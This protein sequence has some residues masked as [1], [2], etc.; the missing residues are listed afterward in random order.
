[1]TNKAAA[2]LVL[3]FRAA[4]ADLDTPHTAETLV[5]SGSM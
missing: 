3:D 2:R 4:K 5:L 1:M